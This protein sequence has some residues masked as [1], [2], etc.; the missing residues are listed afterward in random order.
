M[1]SSSAVLLSRS[2]GSSDLSLIISG[3]PSPRRREKGQTVL[4]K[5]SRSKKDM[6]K[7]KKIRSREEKDETKM[8]MMVTSAH[9]TELLP[10]IDIV[11]TPPLPC[12][13]TT[14]P[15]STTRP[16]PI[17]S[18]TLDPSYNPRTPSHRRSR[19][20][21][22]VI[23]SSQPF[24]IDIPAPSHQPWRSREAWLA[25]HSSKTP[26]AEDEVLLP[27]AMG[28]VGGWRGKGGGAFFGA[29]M[30]LPLP[31]IAR[32]RSRAVRLSRPGQKAKTDIPLTP[33][34]GALRPVGLGHITPTSS[35]I[36]TELYRQASRSLRYTSHDEG[37]GPSSSSSDGVNN[38]TQLRS[39]T[40][41]NPNTH[42]TVWPLEEAQSS[43]PPSASSGDLLPP[44][45]PRTVRR[46]ESFTSSRD[47]TPIPWGRSSSP[48]ILLRT[49]PRTP[50]RQ[51]QQQPRRIQATCPLATSLTPTS[52]M[53]LKGDT[54]PRTWLHRSPSPPLSAGRR[55]PISPRTPLPETPKH[56]IHP[57]S[58]SRVRRSTSPHKMRMGTRK[59]TDITECVFVERADGEG[60]EGSPSGQTRRFWRG[61]LEWAAERK[62]SGR[63]TIKWALEE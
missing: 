44:L 50:S 20:F 24:S 11:S 49:P 39:T 17:K 55:I 57:L 52:S 36:A 5:K 16:R 18:T 15:L 51:H 6:Y 46:A 38:H 37:D 29:D 26:S 53:K 54:M 13:T 23:T 32:V 7:L 58:L 12:T 22:E 62:R 9:H 10:P 34:V 28:D 42:V 43:D 21:S 4:L 60:E 47:S 30:S 27:S 63:G 1:I 40:I 61:P 8:M 48:G 33:P 41:D 19:S 45:L 31:G 2:P 25:L 3:S 56:S 59:G 14:F 35:G